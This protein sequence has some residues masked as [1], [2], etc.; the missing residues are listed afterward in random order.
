[1]QVYVSA[2]PE[3][4]WHQALLELLDST[5]DIRTTVGP[6]AVGR[7]VGVRP[8]S[9]H[10]HPGSPRLSPL[11]RDGALLHPCVQLQE[12]REECRV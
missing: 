5:S 8:E 4:F 7:V 10:T 6:A 2:A 12:P 3:L 11:P 1:M 9:P